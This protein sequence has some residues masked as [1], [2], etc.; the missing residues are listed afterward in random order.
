MCTLKN[1]LEYMAPQSKCWESPKRVHVWLNTALRLFGTYFMLETGTYRRVA[2]Y[3]NF[4]AYVLLQ[5][6]H[7]LKIVR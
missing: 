5:T 1:S 2:T 6:K 3:K 4:T 7:F